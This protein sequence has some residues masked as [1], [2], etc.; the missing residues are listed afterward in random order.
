MPTSSLT[1]KTA[2]EATPGITSCGR[3]RG[4]ELLSH[5]IPPPRKDSLEKLA[6]CK[7]R[8]PPQTRARPEKRETLAKEIGKAWQK[9]SQEHEG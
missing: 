3:F 4:S 7:E 8:F 1:A 6:G 9:K 2:V 5:V